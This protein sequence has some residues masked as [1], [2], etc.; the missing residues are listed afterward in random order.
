[1]RNQNF[2]SILTPAPWRVNFIFKLT[3][4]FCLILTLFSL[5][6]SSQERRINKKLSPLVSLSN[7]NVVK[8]DGVNNYLQVYP[9]AQLNLQA[10]FTIE[11]WA[12]MEDWSADTQRQTGILSKSEHGAGGYEIAL[13]L[14]SSKSIG[15]N[16][17][18]LNNVNVQ[19]SRS[20]TN[21]S[22]GWHHFTGTFDG[23]S[24]KFYTDGVLSSAKDS[25]SSACTVS[26]PYNYELRFG[27]SARNDNLGNNYF[28]GRIDEA[29]IY[30]KVLTDV[31]I[32]NRYNS[33]NGAV[34]NSS[35]G[36]LVAGWHF[37]EPEGEIAADFSGKNLHAYLMNN[38]LWI[39]RILLP[40]SII[41]LTTKNINEYSTSVSWLTA[42]PSDS[43]IEYGTTTEYGKTATISNLVTEHE[44]N[45]TGLLPYTEYH[46][47]II[48]VNQSGVRITSEDRIFRTLDSPPTNNQFFVSPNGSP[49]NNGSF[50]SPWD[51]QTALNHPAAIRPGAII[52]LRGGR[53]FVP[54]VEGGFVSNLKGT[55]SLPI[56]VRSNPGEW[57]IIDG[58]LSGISVKN[59]TILRIY[60]S[61][62]WFMNFEITN[63][64]T[65][66]RKIEV[67]GSNPSE[68]RGN[69]LDDYGI[70]TK[71]INLIIHDTGQGIGAWQQGS[72]NEYYGN[73]IYNNGWDAP[74]RLH[75][76]GT[77][78]Q[79]SV[80]FKKFINNV[81]FNQFGVNSRTGGTDDSSVRNFTWEGNTFFNGSMAWLGPNIENLKVLENYT[82]NNEFKVGNEV[83]STYHDAEVRN[84]YFTN[85]VQLFQYTNGL[86]FQNNTVWNSNENGKNIIYSTNTC[87]PQ[88]NLQINNNTYYQAFRRYPY[89]HFRMNCPG[90][91]TPDY[92]FNK[93]QGSQATTY[94]YTGKSWQDDLDFDLNS[95]Y[96]DSA[97]SENKIFIRRNAYDTN[98]AFIIIYN[99]RKAN[100]VNVN[101]N[102]ILNEGD[103]YELRNVQNYFEDFSTGTYNGSS[104]DIP[105]NGRS[106]AKPIG[107][108]QVSS[109]YHNPFQP[110]TFPT[111]G[112]FELIK[113]WSC[114]VIEK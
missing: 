105:M 49:L 54:K 44:V 25:G 84:N 13:D 15:M 39:P 111:F 32:A 34:A 70:G 43:K 94:N 80:G 77:Y 100:T 71:V 42:F 38:P 113:T 112:V 87:L 50:G 81:F 95:A 30:N 6:V 48:S 51:L 79:N 27:R 109:W 1:M 58:N 31:E 8:L 26:Y 45:L 91:S 35:S 19:A 69:S 89:W 103:H 40:N 24:V 74:D 110:D 7:G 63:S 16:V 73:I 93:T 75:G 47:R 98:R 18:C 41:A 88:T 90:S 10:P 11:L 76:H 2:H 64:E 85:G 36:N 46:F 60:G 107:S 101:L 53:Y 33:G 23:R 114:P 37:D 96:V 78:A 28:D 17:R 57:A 104:L 86:Q 22:A 82:Y 9:D 59:K 52:W 14:N 65:S 29:C 55:A 67:T 102:S 97:P 66:N 5:P 108:E 21:L 4:I 72:N 99:W 12:Y 56:V 106:Q 92:A 61:H 83:N 20:R 68:R 62:T 3:T